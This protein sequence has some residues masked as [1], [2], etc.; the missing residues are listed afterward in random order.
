M[1]RRE[2]S[3]QL[4]PRDESLLA[5]LLG[6]TPHKKRRLLTFGRKLG[7]QLRDLIFIVSFATGQRIDFR[8]NV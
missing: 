3:I 2:H 1:F 7:V 4:N 8:D 6:A 5:T